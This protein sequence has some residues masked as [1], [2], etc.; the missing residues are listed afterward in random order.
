MSEIKFDTAEEALGSAAAHASRGELALADII[1]RRVIEREPTCA[2]A[3]N[4]IGVI[5]AQVGLLA[6]AIEYFEQALARDGGFGPAKQNLQQ[7]RLLRAEAAQPHAAGRQKFLLIKAWGYGFWSDV[8][9]VLG[10]LLLAELSGRV[11]VTHWGSNSLFTDGSDRDAFRL[12]FEPVSAVTRADLR[13]LDRADFFPSKWSAANLDAEDNAKWTGRGS[14]MGGV[15]YLNRP[16]TVAVADFYIKVFDLMPWIPAQHVLHGKSLTAIHRYLID[17]YLVPRASILARVEADWR[18][19]IGGVPCLAVHVRGSDKRL[20][21]ENIGAAVTAYFAAVDRVDPSWKILLLTDDTRCAAAF[22]ERYGAR[23]AL[24]DSLRTDG[25]L[26]IHYSPSADRVRLGVEVMR[27]TYLALRCE[28]FIGHGAS[29][30]S[31]MAAMLKNWDQGDCVLLAPSQFYESYT[32][33]R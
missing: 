6:E 31:A 9:H 1:C 33:V 24:T 7:A 26:G 28:K 18:R 16:E 17:K 27:D 23:I 19:L 15:Y 3:L 21:V 29:N 22:L 12:Y 8:S 32:R 4:L 11:P 14:R 10:C 2:A 20:E 25:D 13:S 5:A 30:V